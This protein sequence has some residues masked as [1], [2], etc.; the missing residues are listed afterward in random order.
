MKQTAKWLEATTIIMG[1]NSNWRG[2]VWCLSL[3][4]FMFRLK[5]LPGSNREIKST[6]FRSITCWLSPYRS[7]RLGDLC[8]II[9]SPTSRTLDRKNGFQ[10]CFRIV[11][12]SEYVKVSSVLWRRILDWV[13]DWVWTEGGNFRSS[14]H[15]PLILGSGSLV[16]HVLILFVWFIVPV[17]RDSDFLSSRDSTPPRWTFWRLQISFPSVS[18][19]SSSETRHNK[20]TN[21]SSVDIRDQIG[22]IGDGSVTCQEETLK[23]LKNWCLFP[24]PLR[25]MAIGQQWTCTRRWKRI[26]FRKTFCS[27]SAQ[28]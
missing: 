10:D 22:L 28:S 14:R 5:M 4:C 8:R 16:C 9:S 17:M 15:F 18:S 13:P 19:T 24:A 7:R 21:L 6:G 25:R 20:T 2:P 23:G 11:C 12:M 27:T 3:G 1:G 26:T